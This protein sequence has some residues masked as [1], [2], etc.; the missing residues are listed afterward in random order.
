M[1]INAAGLEI[2]KSFE[3]YSSNVYLDPIGIPTIGY[4]SIWDSHGHR[5]TINH[6]SISK[7]EGEILLRNEIKHVERA[8]EKLTEVPLTSNEFSALC[9][10]TYNVGSGN[11]QASTLRNKLNDDDYDGAADE[12]PK[13]RRAGGRI[14]KGLV[15]RREAE[16]ELFLEE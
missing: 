12:F 13:W 10:F 11:Y 9:S 7:D 6:P 16:Q 4:G 15:R 14:L 8:I 2:I 3:G 5:V 1:H